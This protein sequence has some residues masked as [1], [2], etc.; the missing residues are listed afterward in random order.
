MAHT[1]RRFIYSALILALSLPWFSVDAVTVFPS[2]DPLSGLDAYPSAAS[3]LDRQ[4]NQSDS[5]LLAIKSRC[6][7][8]LLENSG[9]AR[10]ACRNDA[11]RSNAL[12]NGILSSSIAHR[13]TFLWYSPLLPIPPPFP[14]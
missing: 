4:C 14:A 11:A 8:Q 5:V 6:N 3:V 13:L 12:I 7:G 1:I 9:T 2:R 10:I